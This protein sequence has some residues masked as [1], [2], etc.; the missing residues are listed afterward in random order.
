MD[1][2]TVTAIRTHLDACTGSITHANQVPA[3]LSL[4]FLEDALHQLEAA[5]D[6]LRQA[7]LRDYMG[8]RP[9]RVYVSNNPDALLHAQ[10]FNALVRDLHASAQVPASHYPR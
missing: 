5:V 2:P 10:N 8:N 6:T 3:E 7:R 4:P 1:T 9:R